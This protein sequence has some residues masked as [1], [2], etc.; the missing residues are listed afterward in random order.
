MQIQ[1]NTPYAAAWV[2]LPNVQGQETVLLVAK[3]TFA[4]DADGK[5]TPAQE[6]RPVEMK[7][8]YRG[9]P[10]RTSAVWESDLAL[11]KQGADAILVGHARPASAGQDRVDV[12]F[13]VGTVRKTVRVFGDRRWEAGA[14]GARIGKTS[15]IDKVPLVY[16]KAF[17]G[18]DESV[19]EA[20]EIYPPNPAGTG[21]R[22][23]AKKLDGVLLPNLEDP[24]H[25]ISRASDRPPPAGFGFF[26]RGWAPRKDW[27]GTYDDAWRK[28]RCPLLPSDFQVR[29]FNAAHPD[30]MLP[31]PLQGGESVVVEN[32]A[33]APTLRLMVPLV[34]LVF[35]V[36]LDSEVKTLTPTLDTLVVDTDASRMVL[37]WRAAFPCHRKLLRLRGFR[38]DLAGGAA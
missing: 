33:A 4:F 26:G 30:L 22:K 12:S 31:Q 32:A 23:D 3:A 11:A 24:R 28:D 35:L 10:D 36:G 37:V 14:F 5:L 2:A 34:G 6:Q 7:D 29:H 17:G 9:E 13:Q 27:A 8:S 16:E 19:P 18:R 1:N 38:L 21:F 15:P 25:L 20:V